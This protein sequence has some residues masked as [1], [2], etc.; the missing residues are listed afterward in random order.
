MRQD[1]L[2]LWP[3]GSGNGSGDACGNIDADGWHKIIRTDHLN[4]R[5]A[6]GKQLLKQQRSQEKAQR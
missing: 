2:H 3:L 6:Q 4:T 5:A 1:R